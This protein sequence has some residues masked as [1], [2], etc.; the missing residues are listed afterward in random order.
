METLRNLIIVDYGRVEELPGY[1]FLLL[2]S[3]GKG[4]KT[5]WLVVKRDLH[6]LSRGDKPLLL[7]EGRLSS[8]E[9]RSLCFKNGSLHL[10][11]EE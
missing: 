5:R 9:E 3:I 7:Q 4:G 6:A 2:K 8:I 11:F 1:I 10:C